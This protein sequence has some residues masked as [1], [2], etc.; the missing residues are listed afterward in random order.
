M[1]TPPIHIFLVEDDKHDSVA[2]R[3]TFK[4]ADIA[5]RITECAYADEA[6]ERLRLDASKFDI[7]VSDYKLPGMNG[8]ELCRKL[9]SPPAKGYF[10]T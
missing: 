10:L 2:F 7:V 5:H 4:K 6:Y 3:G 9:I 8:L 1:N